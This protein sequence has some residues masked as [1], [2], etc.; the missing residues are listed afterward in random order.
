MNDEQQ[1]RNAV[2]SQLFFI[3]ILRLFRSVGVCA[4]VDVRVLCCLLSALSSGHS[5]EHTFLSVKPI[6]D[7]LSLSP[8]AYFSV[9]VPLEKV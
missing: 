1:S 3:F 4:Y 5:V 9:R 6:M 2:C 7:L 8:S